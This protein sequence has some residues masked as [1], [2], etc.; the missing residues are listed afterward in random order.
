MKTKALNALVDRNAIK[1]SMVLPF[2]FATAYDELSKIDTD[3]MRA[4]SKACEMACDN[5]PKFDGKTLVALDVSGSMSSARVSDIASLFSA[6]LLKSNN[7]DLITFADNATYRL[8]N[9][10]DSVMTIKNAIKY[11]AG[12]TNFPSVFKTA[13]KKYDRVILLSDMQSW[14]QNSYWSASPKAAFEEYKK[15][16]DAGDCKFY[17]FDLAGHGTL[18][19]PEN[20]IFLLAGFSDKIFDLMSYLETDK[21]A[22]FKAIDE[23]SLK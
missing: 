8:V 20:D 19:M 21:K 2:R 17:S 11:A 3:A 18:Q 5:V 7:C 15:K 22:I 16:Y 10:D 4:I 6:I 14:I 23:I 9:P 1:K 13:N 12:G